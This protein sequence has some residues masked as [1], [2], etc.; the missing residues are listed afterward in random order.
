MSWDDDILMADLVL[1][2]KDYYLYKDEQGDKTVYRLS[3]CNPVI[4]YIVD[5]MREL[6]GLS[7]Y[8]V[9]RTTNVTKKF[10]LLDSPHSM[11]EGKLVIE[12]HCVYTANHRTKERDDEVKQWLVYREL[13]NL[14]ATPF[15]L[16]EREGESW[17]T[18]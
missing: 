10:I 11:K 3:S 12:G 15:L 5:G 4:H 17:S 7:S 16:M 1:I 2:A 13:L 8:G 6:L 18:S 14:V 9:L